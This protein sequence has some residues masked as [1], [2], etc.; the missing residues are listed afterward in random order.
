VL[1]HDA[2]ERDDREPVAVTALPAILDESA[3]RGLKCV[4][5]SELL[6]P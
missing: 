1:M 6:R 5:V 3:R 4:T 2:A